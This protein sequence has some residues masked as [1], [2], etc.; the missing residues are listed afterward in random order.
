[1]VAFA[2]RWHARWSMTPQERHNLRLASSPLA[3]VSASLGC[4]PR[5][6]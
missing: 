3:V 2:R 4:H 1:M 5:T 6:F